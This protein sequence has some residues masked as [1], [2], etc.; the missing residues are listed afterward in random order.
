MNV[1]EREVAILLPHAVEFDREIRH[2][3]FLCRDVVAGFAKAAF[4]FFG[5]DAEK[6]RQPDG[7]LQMLLQ[8]FLVQPQSQAGSWRHAR[9]LPL[10]RDDH[11]F[12]FEFKICPLDRDHADLKIDGKLADRRNRL[13]F[14]P[15]PDRD[16]PL[17]LLHDL[18]VDRP[19]VGL[20]DE[21]TGI[22]V[23]ILS[24]LSCIVQTFLSLLK[25]SGEWPDSRYRHCE[26]LIL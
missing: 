4:E 16:S 6:S 2:C 20:G 15:V 13:A 11:T 24:I 22:H 25:V 10:L 3:R 7:L 21:D 1:V 23:C 19:L 9:S 26:K 5:F 14:R 18:E 8:F 17:D 12:T